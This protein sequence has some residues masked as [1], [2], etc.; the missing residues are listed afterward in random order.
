MSTLPSLFSAMIHGERD[1]APHPDIRPDEFRHYCFVCRCV[2]V[3]S[4]VN[5]AGKLT[6]FC[7]RCQEGDK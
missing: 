1:P 2:T 7:G 5:V 4:V 6:T 3:H